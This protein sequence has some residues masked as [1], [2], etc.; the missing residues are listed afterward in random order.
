[1]NLDIIRSE[2][3]RDEGMKLFPYRDTVGKLTI[4]VGRNLD[5]VGITQ[6]EAAHLLD[7][8][9]QRTA[10]GLDK[11]LG[12]WRE[13]DEVRQRV[14]LNMAF[15]MGIAGLMGFKNTLAFI[16][17]GKYQEAADGMLNSKWAKQV[18]QRAIRLAAMMRNGQ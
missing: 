14:L 11:A 7:G 17:E 5:D 16:H 18:G 8:D 12:W 15:N 3:I 4:G 1:M 9:I 13:I 2:L 10:E 6:M